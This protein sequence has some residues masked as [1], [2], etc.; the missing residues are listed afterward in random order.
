MIKLVNK[1]MLFSV[2]LVDED[3]LYQKSIHPYL[4]TIDQDGVSGYFIL[5]RSPALPLQISEQG[6]HCH[7]LNWHR[8]CNVTDIHIHQKQIV[9]KT[10][11]VNIYRSNARNRAGASYR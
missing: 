2:C 11:T 3:F 1:Y 10:A 5:A 6:R 7:L 9:N 8:S 4:V